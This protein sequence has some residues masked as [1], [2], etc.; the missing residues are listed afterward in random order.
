MREFL[1]QKVIPAIQ[2]KWPRE[3]A[4]KTI[5]IQQDNA[6]THVNP[7]DGAFRAAASQSGFDIQLMCQPSNSPDLN[8]LDLGFFSSIQSLQYRASPKT[9]DDLIQVV[10]KEFN[11]YESSKVNKIF[12]TLQSCMIEIMKHRG[13]NHYKTPHMR[14]DEL[15]RLGCLPVQLS[16]DHDLYQDVL[17]YLDSDA[18]M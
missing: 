4:G 17:G 8:I 14:K 18:V 9:I 5:F 16:C 1:I 10:E 11:D 2:S 13:G 12:L 7:T 3:D 15:E 6:R